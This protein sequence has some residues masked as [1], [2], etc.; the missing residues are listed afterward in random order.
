[1]PYTPFFGNSTLFGVGVSLLSPRTLA[2][3]APNN[4]LLSKHRCG[5]GFANRRF[6]SEGISINAQ[7]TNLSRCLAHGG[8][9]KRQN[10]DASD[11]QGC[12]KCLTAWTTGLA[13][14]PN[15]LALCVFIPLLRSKR[16]SENLAIWRGFCILLFWKRLLVAV[17][18]TRIDPTVI[19]RRSI[20]AQPAKQYQLHVNACLMSLTY[21]LILTFP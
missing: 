3:M 5:H 1:M 15:I 12:A 14:G 18:W 11:G 7:G 10:M 17:L 4:G 2:L 20:M 19:L 13:E 16:K 21:N 6:R 9:F 8:K